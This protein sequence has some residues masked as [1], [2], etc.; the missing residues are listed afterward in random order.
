MVKPSWRKGIPLAEDVQARLRALVKE[1]GG[2]GVVA[3]L[4][5]I[6]RVS[7]VRAAAGLGLRRGTAFVIETKLA[8]LMPAS[9]AA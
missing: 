5:G 2:E 6:G 4:L 3:E 8:A 9:R 1:K 7:V